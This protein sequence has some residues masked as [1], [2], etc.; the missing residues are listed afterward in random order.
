MA[1]QAS[2]NIEI[3]HVAHPVTDLERSVA[4]YCDCL[5]F[6]LVG[7]DAYPTMRQAFVSLGKGG[8]TIELFT[9]LAGEAAKPRRAADHLAFEAADLDAY[10]ESV[11]AAGL[12]VPPIEAFEGGMRHFALDD[13][14][15]L[16]LDFFQGRD[17]YEAFISRNR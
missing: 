4:F 1:G 15:G 10:R 3:W 6:E 9:P 5:G 14:D 7:R 8:F 13:P 11:I 16:R 2:R 17:A 12:A